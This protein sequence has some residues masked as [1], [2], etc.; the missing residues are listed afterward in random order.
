[1]MP[2]SFRGTRNPHNPSIFRRIVRLSDT[3][4]EILSQ[5]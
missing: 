4:G 3:I 2:L 5:N 1:V